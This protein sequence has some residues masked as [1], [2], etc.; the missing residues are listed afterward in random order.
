VS[1]GKE[2]NRPPCFGNPSR[3]CY[4]KTVELGMPDYW[5]CR[6]CL[7]RFYHKR[8]ITMDLGR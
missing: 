1:E 6:E 2:E 4:K 7:D 3:L 5:L 8:G